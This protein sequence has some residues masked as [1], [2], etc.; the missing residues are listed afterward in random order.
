MWIVKRFENSYSGFTYSL[1]KWQQDQLSLLVPSFSTKK[2]Q[3]KYKWAQDFWWLL[4]YDLYQ[5]ESLNPIE[6]NWNS[7][8]LVNPGKYKTKIGTK[9]EN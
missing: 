9:D 6:N 5:K 3:L 4:G 8:S 1:T 2:G 7:N